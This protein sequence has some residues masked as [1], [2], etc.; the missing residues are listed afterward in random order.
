MSVV[1][2]AMS[3]LSVWSFSPIQETT[4]SFLVKFL[5]VIM[6]LQS[7][8]KINVIL[9]AECPSAL[10]L[11]EITQDIGGGGPNTM[12]ECFLSSIGHGETVFSWLPSS[13]GMGM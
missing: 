3:D 10:L 5:L 13:C 2:P 11:R 1:F 12:E 6:T 7:G 4:M 9:P 8:L